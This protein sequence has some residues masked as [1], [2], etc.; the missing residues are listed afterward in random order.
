MDEVLDKTGDGLQTVVLTLQ[1]LEHVV[2]AS[3]GV[4]VTSLA[5]TLGTTKSRIHRHLQTLV[6]EGYIIQQEDSERY[7]VGPKLIA[8]GQTVSSNVDLM[9]AAYDPLMELRDALGHS[10]VASQIVPDGMRVMVTVPG[11][12]PIE[13]GVRVGS[14][15]SFH[16]SAQGKA[17]V[18]F[19]SPQFQARVLRSKLELFTPQTVISPAV[20][21]ADFDLIRKQGWAVAP[22][23]AAVG[24]NTLA[25]PI[26]DVAG[27]VCGAIGIVDMVQFIG[28]TPS[29]DQIERTMKAAARV[30][31]GLGHNLRI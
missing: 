21:A 24:L 9:R 26:F 18:A 22:H 17:A 1:I 8:L 29:D 2:K 31:A 16:G 25:A 13:I 3:R 28:E 23:Q 6:Q 30:S 4:G 15:L 20:L 14:T 5:N 12:S 19:S 27:M 10:A 11:R 7:E